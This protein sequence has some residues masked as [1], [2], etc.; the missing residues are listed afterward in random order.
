ME[1]IHNILQ[2]ENKGSFSALSQYQG[3]GFWVLRAIYSGTLA[4]LPLKLSCWY[5]T[6][7]GPDTC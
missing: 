3:K 6:D 2:S 1:E 7:A 4:I 5:L